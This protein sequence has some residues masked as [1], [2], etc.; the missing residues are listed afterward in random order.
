MRWSTRSRPWFGPPPAS[1]RRLRL[2]H[3]TA[4][5]DEP[6]S[7]LR[8]LGVTHPNPG[9]LVPAASITDLDFDDWNRVVAGDRTGVTLSFRAA[10]P[11][12]GP[13]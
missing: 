3:A 12:L 10:I 13:E 2:R 6:V 5:I 1:G 11:H 8:S 9:L 7:E 4:A